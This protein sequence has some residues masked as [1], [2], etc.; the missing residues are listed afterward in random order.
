MRAQTY[1]ILKVL[2]GDEVFVKLEP[3]FLKEIPFQSGAED[4]NRRRNASV[5]RLGRFS[6]RQSNH[7]YSIPFE[8]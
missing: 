8:A 2:P 4:I 6:N 1:R 7:T 3:R 5:I